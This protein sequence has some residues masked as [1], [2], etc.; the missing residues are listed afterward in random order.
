[1]LENNYEIVSSSA[2]F[3]VVKGTVAVTFGAQLVRSEVYDPV[4]RVSNPLA[5][6]D[7]FAIFDSRQ[8]SRSVA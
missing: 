6:N 2:D 5:P 7:L 1:M 8:G 3:A 4:G